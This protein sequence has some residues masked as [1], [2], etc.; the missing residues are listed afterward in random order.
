MK[1]AAKER[2]S[3]VEDGRSQSKLSSVTSENPLHSQDPFGDVD[4]LA[5]EN[6]DGGQKGQSIVEEDVR[7]TERHPGGK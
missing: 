2:F 6:E 5:W 7:Q 4:Q 1:N 3:A